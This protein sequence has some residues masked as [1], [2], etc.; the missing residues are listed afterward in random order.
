MIHRCGANQ[1]RYPT[2]FLLR[3]KVPFKK[4][5]SRYFF[6]TLSLLFDL[7]F[8]PL[9]FYFFTFF[10]NLHFFLFSIPRSLQ[11]ADWANFNSKLLICSTNIHGGN[12][13]NGQARGLL[14]SVFKHRLAPL[15]RVFRAAIL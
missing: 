15:S 9:S 2:H 14:R 3:K 8:A 12:V 11:E 13:H 4:K 7:T 6:L 1:C 5:V 10:S